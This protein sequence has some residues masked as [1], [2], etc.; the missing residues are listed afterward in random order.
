MLGNVARVVAVVIEGGTD[1]ESGRTVIRPRSSLLDAVM[2]DDCTSEGRQWC[3]VEVELAFDL[4]VRG[5]FRLIAGFS[6]K[7]ESEDDWGHQQVPLIHGE[8]GVHAAEA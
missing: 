5:Q 7:V 3:G 2:Y 8:V 4:C 1:I 6:L